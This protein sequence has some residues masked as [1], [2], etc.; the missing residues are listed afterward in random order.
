MGSMASSI[1]RNHKVRLRNGLRN[2]SKTSSV[3]GGISGGEALIVA[4]KSLSKLETRPR[5]TA[6]SAGT[7]GSKMMYVDRGFF[8]PVIQKARLV[9]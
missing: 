3:F 7:P 5:S 9:P 6:A 1:E 4:V 2:V 8:I